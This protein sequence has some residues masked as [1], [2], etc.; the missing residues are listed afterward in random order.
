[1]TVKLNPAALHQLLDS[2]TGPVGRDL[3]RRTV[4]VLERASVNASGE[5]LGI[6]TGDLLR[7]LHDEITHDGQGLVGKVVTTATHRGF[8]YPAYWDRNGRPWLTDALRDGF[9]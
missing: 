8:N 5:I 1:M 4:Q 2:E 9:R 7:G 3:R 6:D